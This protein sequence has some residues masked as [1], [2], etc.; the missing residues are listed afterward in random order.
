MRSASYSRFA[1]LLLVALA[2][3]PALAAPEPPEAPKPPLVERYLID[4]KLAEGEAALVAELEK[5]P[6]NDQL[7]FG[8][9]VVQFL[10]GVE[11]LMQTLYHYGLRSQ[12]AWSLPILRLPVPV[13][14]EPAT[15]TYQDERRL[16][17]VFTDDLL[18]TDSTLAAVKDPGVKLPLR[19]G[20]IRLDINGDGEA[21][22]DES[23]WRIY[24]KLTPRARISAEV[25]EN[26]VLSLDRGDVH[27]LRG[28]CHLLSALCET[29]LAYDWKV[30][31]DHTAAMVFAKPETP[32]PVL[33]R[34]PNDKDPWDEDL[35]DAIAFVHLLS[36]DVADPQR[37]LRA[38]EHLETVIAQSRASWDHILAETDNDHEWIPN[39]NQW[40]IVPNLRVT[41][42]VVDGWLSFLNEAEAILAGKKLIPYWRG[43]EKKGV[44]LRRVFTEP[45]KFDLVLW[46]HGTAAL[47]YLEEGPLTESSFWW[48]MWQLFEGRFLTFAVWFN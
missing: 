45:R 35:F 32:F 42:Q 37:L 16:L 2:P 47:P 4:G 18:Q 33:L 10:R 34:T 8:L 12:P 31:F 19:F 5:D 41:K 11:Q 17:E 7:R 13:N 43:S 20:L 15:I 39:P 14:P 21:T 6:E 27:W 24:A 46:V 30:N 22:E 36:V 38:L 23:F 9:G 40:G 44:N 26:F 48:R 29:V 3:S 25:A 1:I 28:Y